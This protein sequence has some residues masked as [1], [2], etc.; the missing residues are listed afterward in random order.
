MAKITH[1]FEISTSP[2]HSITSC[3]IFPQWFAQVLI[4]FIGYQWF[5]YTSTTTSTSFHLQ[6]YNRTNRTT[7]N[8][9]KSLRRSKRKLTAREIKACISISKFSACINIDF[10]RVLAFSTRPKGKSKH[11]FIREG[12]RGNKI[13]S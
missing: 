11:E 2:R 6:N 8:K 4:F 7:T 13:N 9:R 12:D 10:Q 1:P 3:N 5:F